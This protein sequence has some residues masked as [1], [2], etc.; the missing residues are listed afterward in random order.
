MRAKSLALGKVVKMTSGP[1]RLFLADHN[2][3]TVQVIDGLPGGPVAIDT[4]G[5]VRAC[6][7]ACVV[8]RVGC[9]S[10]V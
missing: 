8:L 6:V 9:E 10:P 5:C 4:R 1:P 7:R 2:G 3:S